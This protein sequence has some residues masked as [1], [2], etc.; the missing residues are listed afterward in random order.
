MAKEI[1]FTKPVSKDVSE[2]KEVPDCFAQ[3]F[4]ITKVACAKCHDNEICSIM[5]RDNVVEKK[6]KTVEAKVPK[7]IDKEENQETPPENPET[8]DVNFG[9]IDKKKLEKFLIDA[10]DDKDPLRVE[11]LVKYT[12]QQG[13]TED[14]KAA[15]DWLVEFIKESGKIKTRDGFVIRK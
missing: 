3:V 14:R 7:I 9:I 5:Y 8:P 2:Y 12:M 10:A 11:A 6:I 1:D 13:K 4:D 15:I